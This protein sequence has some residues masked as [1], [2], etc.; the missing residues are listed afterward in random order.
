MKTQNILRLFAIAL[1]MLILP[2]V[3]SQEIIPERPSPPRLVNDF[4]GTLNASELN[5]LEQKLVAFNDTTSTQIAVVLVNTLGD[6]DKAQFADLLGE[7]WGVGHKGKDNGL[8]VL[9]KPKT[10][11]EKGEAFIATGYGLEGAVPDAVVKR[12]IEEEMIPHFM[13]NRYFEG[14]DRATD[15]LM[16]LT[17]G[18]FTAEEYINSPPSL[19]A[20]LA[21]LIPL[22]IFVFFVV[23][24]SSF[25]KNTMNINGKGAS[26]LPLW[27]ALFLAS[28]MGQQNGKWDS[29]TSGG[30]SFGSG[31]FGGGGGFGGFGGGSFGGGGAG[32]SW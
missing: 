1:I 18:E 5:R 20:L 3:Q 17:A 13:R 25:R 4:T 9:V 14:L 15:I 23:F 22:G 10:A 28:Q 7:K 21:I 30:S 26:G 24:I 27:T 2:V 16:S 12:I 32:G 29:F 6:Y 19:L 11:E 8:V 31:G